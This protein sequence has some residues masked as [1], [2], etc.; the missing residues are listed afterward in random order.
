MIGDFQV[1]LAPT[2]GALEANN[3]SKLPAGPLSLEI[4]PRKPTSLPSARS[5]PP[6]PL[7]CPSG[8]H[9]NTLQIR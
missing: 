7:L 4:V 5:E 8:N 6:L 9:P 3:L 1:F 2:D